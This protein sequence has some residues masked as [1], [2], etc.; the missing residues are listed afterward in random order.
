MKPPRIPPLYFFFSGCSSR[1]SVSVSSSSYYLHCPSNMAPEK[2]KLHPE[3]L[4]LYS[5]ALN[6]RWPK[7]DFYQQIATDV[8]VFVYCTLMLPWVLA[9]VLGLQGIEGTEEATKH[10]T[11]AM[12]RRHFRTTIKYQARLTI[13]HSEKATAVDG[14][15]IAGLRGEAYARVEE[16]IGTKQRSKVVEEVEIELA[17]NE[18][19]NVG[20]FVYVW[21]KPLSHLEPTHWTPL[22]FMGSSTYKPG[23]Q[24]IGP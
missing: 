7:R 6:N 9:R 20:A 10:M 11:R 4:R 21:N 5:L 17:N 2:K 18:K 12:L 22:D 15:L 19:V 8:P 24:S 1:A 16:Y 13:V 3:D 14:I 23:D